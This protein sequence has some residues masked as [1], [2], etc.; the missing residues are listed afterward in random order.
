VHRTRDLLWCLVIACT[1]ASGP[2]VSRPPIQTDAEQ[3][4][5]ETQP[6]SIRLDIVATYVNESEH[7]VALGQCTPLVPAFALEK[8]VVDA[9]ERLF[10]RRAVLWG[11]LNSW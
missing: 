2:D 9:G 6:G 11:S 8:R 10:T 1:D 7:P 4:R 5:L 3:Y